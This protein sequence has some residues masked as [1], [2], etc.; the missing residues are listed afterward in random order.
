M[1]K[2][3]KLFSVLL[4]IFLS[5]I[6]AHAVDF[7]F[8]SPSRSVPTNVKNAMVGNVSRLLTEINRACNS[9]T[10]LN[11]ANISMEPGAKSRLTHLWA[12][13]R[14]ECEDNI[15]STNCIHDVQ[16]Y[17]VRG[18]RVAMKPVN[19][20]SYPGKLKRELTISFNKTGQISGVRL[21]LDDHENV[22]MMLKSGVGVTD[23]RERYEILK[24]VEDFR[25]Y[26]NEK[27]IKA[28]EQI[29]SDDALIITG[30]VM[31]PRR[32]QRESS[33]KLENDVKYNVQTKQQYI[34]NLR[35]KFQTNKYINVDFSHINIVHHGSKQNIYGVELFQKWS[36]TGYRDEGYLFL[37]WDFSDPE[38]PQIHV[39]TWQEKS[40]M[41]RVGGF[42]L[43]D[44]FIP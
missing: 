1:K 28:L 13:A 37:L 20:S 35:T 18:I 11:L 21:A 36:T 27:D 38:R 41:E 43:D 29:F 15:I 9:G 25:C 33:V 24:W 7:S 39:R 14:F 5:T 30:S 42:G 6:S 17:Q 22:S 26:Y 40:E 31:K 16:G 19:P 32:M 12:D 44:F 3:I 2:S 8:S 23:A 4:S 34:S 10:T